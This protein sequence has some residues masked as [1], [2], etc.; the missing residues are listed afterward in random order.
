M[1]TEA[2]QTNCHHLI[3][4]REEHDVKISHS[5]R[6]QSSGMAKIIDFEKAFGKMKMKQNIR[7]QQ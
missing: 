6:F 1:K 3:V 7:Y 4:M 5:S 2:K